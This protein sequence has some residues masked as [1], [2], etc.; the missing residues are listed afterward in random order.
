MRSYAESQPAPGGRF[1]LVMFPYLAVSV[2]AYWGATVSALS[3]RPSVFGPLLLALFAIYLCFFVGLR[4]EVGK[5]WLQYNY[6]YDSISQMSFPQAI[7]FTDWGYA[8][9][10]WLSFQLGLGSSGVFFVCAMILVVGIVMFAVQTPYPWMAVAVTMPHVVTVMAMD[11]VRQATALGFILIGLSFLS[12]SKVEAFMISVV[13]GA[14]FHRTGIIVFGFGLVLVSKNKWLLYPA[15][16]AIAAV[17]FQYMLADRLDVYASRYLEG[18]AGSHGALIRLVQNAAPAAAFLMLGNR[19]EL[20]DKFRKI[21]TIMAWAAIVTVLVMPV[22][23]S[24]VV[25]DRI[26]KYFLPVQILFF[27]MLIARFHGALIRALIAG[28]VVFYL[29]AQQVYWLSN[30]QLAEEFWLPYQMVPI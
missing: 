29:L 15:F 6:I 25:I 11:H 10:N 28:L 16:M 24:T 8:A 14:L 21:M 26:G 2:V 4:F 27:P 19:I 1:L 12:K 23:P 3:R 9:L 5:D 17:L 18:E 7:K 22:S 13:A 20:P 30:S